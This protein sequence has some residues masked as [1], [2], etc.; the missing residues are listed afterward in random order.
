MKRKLEYLR[1]YI[2]AIPRAVS[3]MV[4]VAAVSV[5]LFAL[6]MNLNIVVVSESDGTHHTLLTK[7]TDP[8]EIAD[9][10]GHALEEKDEFFFIDGYDG[11][12]SFLNITRAFSVDV[13]A[14]GQ[15]YNTRFV[16]GTVADAI[17]AT[18]VVLN[19]DDYTEPALSAPL[20]ENTPITVHRV[21]Y[22]EETRLETLSNAEA[23]AYHEEVGT[24]ADFKLSHNSEYEVV[25]QD[26]MVDGLIHSS[27][28]ISVTPTL[29][30]RPLD[31][32][33]FIDGIP[34]SRI[35]GFSDIEM[36]PDALPVNYTR[37]WEGAVCTAYSSSGGK[38]SSGLGLY[39]GT[40]AVNP[41]VIPYGTRMY[42]TSA[43]GSFVYGFCIATD[44]GTAMMEGHVGLDLYFDSF[45][46]PYQ[47]G[48][49]QLNVYILD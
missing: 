10:A 11:G 37:L 36:G 14:D 39:C 20:A 9:L 17:D 19:G 28:I 47:F 40:A 7:S 15:T 48:K 25:Y 2:S 3:V 4:I 34:V 41:N 21:T 31:S 8:H 42:I 22:V 6:M 12:P 38:G 44:T 24:V 29:T 23:D 18:G 35:E 5:I 45:E 33:E 1:R 46:E 43:D 32:Y 16:E 26:R 13:T 30:P 27:K 49:R